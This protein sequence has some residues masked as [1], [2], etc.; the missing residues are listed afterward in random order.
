MFYNKSILSCSR[1]QLMNAVSSVRN[2]ISKPF[3]GRSNHKKI[4][5]WS[6]RRPTK[7]DS[8]VRRNNAEGFASSLMI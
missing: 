1:E 7:N 6:H 5:S 3:K 4:L 2:N 8:K